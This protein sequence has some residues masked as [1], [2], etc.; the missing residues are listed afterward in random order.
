MKDGC[1]SFLTHYREIH[2]SEE[3]RPGRTPTAVC[4]ATHGSVLLRVLVAFHALAPERL[5]DLI[6]NLVLAVGH[7]RRGRQL[8]RLLGFSLAHL[9]KRSTLA[10]MLEEEVLLR[11]RA[12]LVNDSAG[13]HRLG[14]L[15]LRLGENGIFRA[16]AFVGDH[17][18]GIDRVLVVGIGLVAVHLRVKQ[19]IAQ[20]TL[21][22]IL[23][24]HVVVGL[25]EHDGQ[26]ERQVFADF[27]S[28]RDYALYVI[29]P[30]LVAV[31]LAVSRQIT[32][33]VGIEPA[34]AFLCSVALHCSDLSVRAVRRDTKE[35]AVEDDH[36][37]R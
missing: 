2:P 14:I 31:I 19:G 18:P 33:T 35:P 20:F 21:V 7:L 5:S 37:L 29:V 30:A 10:E 15:L 23:Q 24:I 9:L 22:A 27:K 4:A 26:F 13:I 8:A 3:V 6:D 12:F 16:A 32:G 28:L 1:I 17:V 36:R 11:L 34:L 25:I